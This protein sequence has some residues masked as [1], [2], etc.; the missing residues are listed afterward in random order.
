[1][2]DQVQL[3]EGDMVADRYHIECLI[4]GGAFGEVY[5]ARSDRFGEVAVKVLPGDLAPTKAGL[6]LKEATI[7]AEL[8]H[9][10]IVKVLEAGLHT[11]NAVKCGYIVMEYL[12]G[13]T[14]VDYLERKIRI[15]VADAR[16]V[17]SDILS[18]LA[19]AHS[20]DPPIIHGDVK[21]ANIFLVSEDPLHVKLGDFGL[22]DRACS[23]TGMTSAAGTIYYLA[24]ECL[25]GYA[26]PGSDVFSAGLVI[27]QLLTG[28]AAFALPSAS[29]CGSDKEW[30]QAVERS[31]KS[32]PPPPSRFSSDVDEDLDQVVLRSLALDHRERY[33]NA[34]DF[35]EAL[36]AVGCEQS[37]TDVVSA[38]RHDDKSI[39]VFGL[40]DYRQLA[41]SGELTQDELSAL[42]DLYRDIETPISLDSGGAFSVLTTTG[43]TRTE[44]SR[45]DSLS[46]SDWLCHPD[47]SIPELR[48]LK[49][50]GKLMYSNPY[51]QRA[52]RCGMLLYSS[53]IA[54]ALDK[55][56]ERI[57]ARTI[58]QMRRLF[59]GLL[60]WRFLPQKYRS[61]LSQAAKLL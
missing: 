36:M 61:L 6:V 49:H 54:Q 15:S 29:E 57:S 60:D 5:R 16:C 25:W 32:P 37:P 50:I 31:R 46:L 23:E 34:A 43:V 30:R 9:P 41:F 2:S 38:E 55:H 19:C 53:A 48:I 11:Q 21:P 7:L 42:W 4:G 45:L 10:N 27:Y 13:G 8:E 56:G 1:M 52:V 20:L 26:V 3:A 17:G 40:E 33:R 14:L 28:T 58:G 12:A 24:P 18:A 51:S 22:S 59:D 47:T 35:L 39:P 44:L